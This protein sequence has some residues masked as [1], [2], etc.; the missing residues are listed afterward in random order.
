MAKDVDD[1]LKEVVVAHGAMSADQGATYVA[2]L[3][4]AGRY[5][6]DVY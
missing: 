3:A 5:A 4:K 6:R 2:G 1:A